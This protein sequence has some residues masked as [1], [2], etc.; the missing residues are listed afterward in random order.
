MTP[1]EGPDTSRSLSGAGALPQERRRRR[2]NS[3]GASKLSAVELAALCP[4]CQ[5]TG[6]RPTIGL[7]V[8]SDRHGTE[9]AMRLT[10]PKDWSRSSRR[11]LLAFVV[12]GLSAAGWFTW[13]AD[14]L[15]RL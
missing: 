5:G 2:Q 6:L 3:S 14:L 4:C 13:I 12:S 1:S 11:L 7:W 9:V 10:S 8:A 15:G